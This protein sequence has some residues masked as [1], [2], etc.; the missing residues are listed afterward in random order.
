MKDIFYQNKQHLILDFILFIA[1][2]SI[3]FSFAFNSISIAILFFYS[4]VFFK[5]DIFISSIN[6]KE[7][8][9]FYM[10]FFIMQ[11]ISI[12]YS[13]NKDVAIKSVTRNIIF[14]ILPITFINLKNKLDFN[15]IKIIY[16]GLLLAVL[17]NLIS[18][19]F[20]IIR[21]YAF[22]NISVKS[23]V[24]EKFI[25][26]GI[27]DIHVPYLALLIIFLIICTNKITYHYKERLNKGIRFLLIAFLI[28]SLFQLSGVMSI[29]I[30]GLFFIVQF[31]FSNKSNKIKIIGISLMGIT[32]I[33]SIFWL[34]NSNLQERVK[35]SENLIYRAQ[36]IIR[37]N[38][39]VRNE[40]W[41]SVIKVI[42][43]NVFLGVGAGGGLEL[44]QKERQ[45]LSEPYINK[46]NAHND[47]LEIMLR[48]GLVGFGL[49]MLLIIILIKKAFMI[50][51]Y[52]F[53]WFLV[54][55]LISGLTESYLQ[56]QIGLVF[57]VFFSLLFYTLN[58]SDRTQIN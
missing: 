35:G 25:A 38:D 32:F 43:S 17:S 10:L 8:Y 41:G 5:K 31:L 34:K 55:F 44:L 7:V 54:V 23:M 22:E 33:L 49:Y 39:P 56:R 18:A 40:N 13:C 50:K 45:I 27:Y 11:V 48:Y 24:R 4:F 1:A 30:L 14:F 6:V 36:K 15:K 28:I 51:N 16:Y 9:V 3:P 12:Y 58:Q 19:Y 46:H 42:S 52:F 37:Y 20:N 53:I 47:Y 57:F 21:Q 26:N 29:F 2:F